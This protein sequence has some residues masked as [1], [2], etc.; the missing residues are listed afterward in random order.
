MLLSVLTGRVRRNAACKQQ[1]QADGDSFHEKGLVQSGPELRA[2]DAEARHR[3]R[4]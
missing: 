3:L 2:G 4:V 1:S